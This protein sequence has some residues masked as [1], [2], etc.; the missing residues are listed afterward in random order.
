MTD[1]PGPKVLLKI[2]N[3]MIEIMKCLRNYPK[4][5]RYTLGERTESALLSGAENVFYASFNAKSRVERLKEA[6]TQFQM[7]TWLLRIAQRQRFISEGFYENVSADLIE[8]GKMVT[9]WIKTCENF[10]GKKI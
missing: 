1:V 3:L 8:V 9:G 7:V 10:S 4:T 6:R 5:E 2:E